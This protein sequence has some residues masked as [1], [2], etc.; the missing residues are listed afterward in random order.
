[1]KKKKIVILFI[2]VIGILVSGIILYYNF[3]KNCKFL[4]ENALVAIFTGCIFAFPTYIIDVLFCK[5]VYDIIND[6]MYKGYR[7]LDEI[8]IFINS[9]SVENII[10]CAKRINGII[11]QIND[12]RNDS[13]LTTYEEIDE[14][15]LRLTNLCQTICD[16][17]EFDLN[18]IQTKVI[19][20][21]SAIAIYLKMDEYE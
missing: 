12:I 17:N 9:N 21:K 13:V 2:S 10:K 18:Y 16:N 4:L 19:E 14:V 15:T 11:D 3:N 1:M 7:I 20:S 8:S 6:K 5:D